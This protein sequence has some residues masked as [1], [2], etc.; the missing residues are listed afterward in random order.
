[1]SLSFE[2]TEIAFKYRSDKKLKLAHFLF[3]SLRSPFLTKIGISLA[4][5]TVEWNLPFKGL[6]KKTIFQQFCGGETLQETSEV[7]QLLGAYKVNV[8]LDY[9]VEGKHSE[10]D[11]DQAVL[12]F[13]KAIDY[14]AKQTNI[15]FIPLKPT[16]FGRFALLEKIH[17]GKSLSETEKEEYQRFSNRIDQICEAAAQHHLMVLI[18]A[19][20]SWI[21]KP[22]DDLTNYVMAKYNKQ[23]VI[24][25]NTFQ[26]YCHDR[27]PYLKTSFEM[28][29]QGG[30]LLGA[31]LVRGAYMEI[32]R[33]RAQEKGYPSP[34]NPTKE[35]TDKD[36]NAA[37]EFCLQHYKE[38]AVFIG[39]HNEESCL[40]GVQLM[41]K[42]N[43]P[44]NHNHVHF[45]QLYGMSDNIT[46]NLANEGYHASKYLPYGPVKDVIPYLLRRAQENTSVAGQTGREL[47]LI[48]KEM[49][50]RGL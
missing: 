16:G 32:E 30:Y 1:M 45:A 24:V 8:A 27:L 35:A 33:E 42:M 10:K 37:I 4:K 31:K 14:A 15:P 25:F 5:K 36:Y 18:D 26:L 13:F 6:I 23:E 44:S 38:I 34:I 19:E 9:G 28:A 40:L 41:K 39:T 22:I 3:N 47:S 21:Q 17:A 29:Q 46:F 11:F 2:N 7:A 43:I 50:R 20:H 48:K 12:E 49:K